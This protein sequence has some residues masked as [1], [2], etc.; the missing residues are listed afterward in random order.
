MKCREARELLSAYHD[1]ELSARLRP[2]VAEHVDGCPRCGEELTRFGQLSAMQKGLETPEPPARIW[3]GIEAA[4]DADREA[5]PIGRPTTKQRPPAKRRRQSLMAAAAILLIA[6]VGVW[7]TSTAWHAPGRHQAL[8]AD[9]AEYLEHFPENPNRAQQVLLAK[10]GGRPVDFSEAADQLG[11]RP[12][13]STG[14]PKNYRLESVYV[15]DMP[16]CT[17]VQTICR[18]DDGRLF[19]I[20][21]HDDQH[22]AWLADRPRI[23]TQC[24][25]CLCSV[26]QADHGL[27]ASW[28]T[29]KRQLTVVGAQDLEEIADLITHFQARTP[30]A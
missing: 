30:E 24:E 22:P 7:I 16:C 10:Y 19:A 17:C 14:L 11:Y 9:F 2:P 21:E 25:G 27:I 3:T 28:K 29:G 8:A 23:D 13:T 18:R 5:A 4:L 20:F 12:V 6:T 15:L 1:G 26:V